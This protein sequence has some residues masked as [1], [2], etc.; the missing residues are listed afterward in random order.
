MQKLLCCVIVAASVA[1]ASTATAGELKLSIANGRATLIA[2]DVP[3]RQI[4]A[5]WARLGDTTIVNG[6]RVPGP[7][8]TLQLVDRPEREVLDAVLRTVAGYVA[9]PRNAAAANLSVYDRILILPT[10]QAPA[11][12]PAAVSTPTFS[13]PPRPVPMPDDDPVEHPNEMPPGANMPPGM[14]PQPNQPQQ[15]TTQPAPGM[16]QTIPRPGMLPPPP[17][18][19]TPNIYNPNLPGARPPG[20]LPPGVR[21]PGGGDDDRDR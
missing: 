10:S 15:P 12:N 7:N 9:A 18:S 2:T 17:G 8:L 14:V 21:P 1:M 3:V 19:G 6:E 5:E 4:L 16:P 20:T 11:Y 13:P